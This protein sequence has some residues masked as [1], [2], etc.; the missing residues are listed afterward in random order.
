MSPKTPREWI[1]RTIKH[2][3]TGAVPY[4]FM[5]S[6]PVQR[7]A[8]RHYGGPIEDAL[9]LPIRMTVP[10]SIK[11][12]Y[13]D[14]S[15]FGPTVTGEYGVVWSTNEIDRGSPIG[16]CLKGPTLAG[17]SFPDPTREYRFEDIEAWTLANES[18]Y[19]IIWVGDLWERA[20]FMRGMEN[21]L[22]DVCLH[23]NFVILL[24]H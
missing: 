19:R 1:K 10:K 22:L 17:Y 21:L 12:L 7:L 16:P 6:P 2:E 11:P 5:F 13:A 14:P 24:L 8:E 3:E 9:N 23:R 4:N 18:Y 20:T 15:E